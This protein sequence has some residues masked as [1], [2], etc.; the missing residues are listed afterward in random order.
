MLYHRRKGACLARSDTNDAAAPGT[1]PAAA[2]RFSAALGGLAVTLARGGVGTLPFA[3]RLA[4]GVAELPGVRGA[5]VRD[6]DDVLARVGEAGGV[7]LTLREGRVV[8]VAGEIDAA[9]LDSLRELACAAWC[10]AACTEALLSRSA[11]LERGLVE[12]HRQLARLG[13]RLERLAEGR[14]HFIA[15]AS[16][17]LR[18]PLSVVLGHCQLMEEGLL[19]P[20]QQKR[21]IETIRRQTDRMSRMVDD[22][23]DR[24][25]R[26]SLATGER[27]RGDIVRAVREVA[28]SY[29]PLAARRQ[30]HV[31][32]AGEDGSP[33][34]ADLAALREALADLLENALRHTSDGGTVRVKVEGD[35]ESVRVEVR[36]EG[37]ARDPFD[38]EAAG[39]GAG[40]RSCARIVAAQGGLLRWDAAPGG[41]AIARMTLPR[42]M[43]GG[44]GRRVLL[45]GNDLERLEAL[46][47]ALSTAWDPIVSLEGPA[48]AI[49]RTQPRAVVLDEG[50][51]TRDAV[52]RLKGDPAFVAVPVVAIVPPDGEGD[53]LAAGAAAAVARPVDAASLA[54]HLRTA[55]RAAEAARTSVTGRTPDPL[56]GL[57]AGEALDTRLRSLAGEARAA[58]RPLPAV[59]VA[60]AD[61]GAFN[62][63]HGW[64]TGDQLLLWLA[65][66]LRDRATQGDVPVRLGGATFALLLPGRAMPYARPL[67]DELE[68]YLA[69]A[70]PR[71]GVARVGVKM[72]LAVVDAAAVENVCSEAL[73]GMLG[74]HRGA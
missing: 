27:E 48:D 16:H 38:P 63:D 53:A 42:A 31:E 52:A 30:Q 34:E 12:R 29:A 51:G 59:L 72:S 13:L 43:E 28:A 15:L 74:E 64:A 37:V 25:R 47:E 73:V 24:Y 69:R 17:D 41:G 61:L 4:E 45:L 56:T 55:L 3:R 6:G 60:V 11:R 10:N 32:V 70:K 40:L 1:P 71:L 14:D 20:N 57:D 5:T 18:S 46:A 36:D 22:L 8:E 49:R 35:A 33:V 9:A 7:A 68:D 54:A 62:R 58:G 2:T 26:G 19:P 67:H 66:E 23:L 65:A 44:L 50:E 21:A 39:K